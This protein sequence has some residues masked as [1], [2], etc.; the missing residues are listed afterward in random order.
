MG[1][2]INLRLIF[3]FKDHNVKAAEESK[4]PYLRVIQ[5][6]KEFSGSA[7]TSEHRFDRKLV[8]IKYPGNVVNPEKAI[9]T[10][11]GISAV[12]TV[13]YTLLIFLFKNYSK[14]LK[15]FKSTKEHFSIQAIDTNNR[16]LELRFRPDDGYS[17]PACGDRHSTCGFL[18]R[19][20]VKKS[21]I[22]QMNKDEEKETKLKENTA[23]GIESSTKNDDNS[24]MENNSE[25]NAKSAKVTKSTENIPPSFN[26]NKYKNLSGDKDYEL[27]NLK[28]LGR[29]DT[30]FKFAS[31][32]K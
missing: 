11:G 26:R 6:A 23:Q 3:C 15:S 22:Q 19:V 10:L 8:C 17:K 4:R 1:V 28:V 13:Y 29:V 18:L 30:E 14:N 9:E 24:A 25:E 21:R 5:S 31:T 7:V 27:P 12:S 16:R 2:W 32:F 20:R